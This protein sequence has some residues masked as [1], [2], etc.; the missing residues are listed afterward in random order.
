MKEIIAQIFGIIGCVFAISS[1]QCKKNKYLFLMQGLCG[2]FF[3]LNFFLIGAVSGALFNVTSVVRAALLFKDGRKLWKVIVINALFTACFAYSL[4]TLDG[5]WLQIFLS[6][7]MF[8]GL[9]M[10]TIFMYK[11]NA[12]HIRYF[13]VA[14]T[15]PSW[16]IYN[17]VNFTLGGII[18]EAFNMISVVVSLIRY[19]KDFSTDR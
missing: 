19:R 7:L 13:Q 4:S 12:K 2:L 6:S 16:L 5:D 3:S 10:M 8:L 11:G 1:F 17:T 14:F 15:S 9:F 18:C